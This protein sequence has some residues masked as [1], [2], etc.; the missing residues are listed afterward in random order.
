M[1]VMRVIAEWVVEPDEKIMF[2]GAVDDKRRLIPGEWMGYTVED[3][4]D[5]GPQKYPCTLVTDRDGARFDFCGWRTWCPDEPALPYDTNVFDKVL[6]AGEHFT[7]IDDE[8]E[9]LTYR[10][11]SVSPAG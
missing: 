11:T 7:V 3:C 2:L 6:V 5:E 10:I 8:G 9:E 4:N 1:T